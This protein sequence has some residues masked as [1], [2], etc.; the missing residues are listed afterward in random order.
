MTSN[1]FR[2][3]SDSFYS[4]NE[5]QGIM[6]CRGVEGA[7]SPLP[8]GGTKEGSPRGCSWGAF[9]RSLATACFPTISTAVSSAMES[10]T[11]EFGMV[12]GVPSPP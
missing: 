2:W 10:L 1:P 9:E 11:A 12:S 7:R 4:G 3:K 8:A 6:P 5:V